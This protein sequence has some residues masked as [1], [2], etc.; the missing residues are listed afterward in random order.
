MPPWPRPSTSSASRLCRFQRDTR[1]P[2]SDLAK[3]LFPNFISSR[4]M[5]LIADLDETV[6]TNFDLPIRSA[7]DVLTRLDRQKVHV[8]YVTARMDVS[9]A[10]TDRFIMEHRLPG[11]RNIHFC[12][13]W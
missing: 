7:V 4:S 1:K 10:G 3:Q 11:W 5:G 8:H 6:C 2:M 13:N 12:P 9:R